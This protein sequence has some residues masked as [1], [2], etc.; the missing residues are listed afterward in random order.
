LV[1]T[2]FQKQSS[3]PGMDP[4]PK[5]KWYRKAG[6]SEG[7]YLQ[8]APVATAKIRDSVEPPQKRPNLLTAT[9]MP[10]SRAFLGRNSDR[11]SA[12]YRGRRLVCFMGGKRRAPP[13]MLGDLTQGL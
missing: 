2:P 12:S 8:I 13:S 5:G 10:I 11:R 1:K 4:S 3:R 6:R 7:R 9:P